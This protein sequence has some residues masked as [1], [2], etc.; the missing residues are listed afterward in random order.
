MCY[1]QNQLQD[2][3]GAGSQCCLHSWLQ[4]TQLCQPHTRLGLLLASVRPVVATSSWLR[5]QQ[6]QGQGSAKTI[7]ESI[8]AF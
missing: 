8:T 4:G 7:T 5:P 1:W 3:R 6:P 2:T